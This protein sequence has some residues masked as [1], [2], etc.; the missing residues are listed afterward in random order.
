M[1]D[2]VEQLKSQASALSVAE[3]ADLAYFLLSSFEPE[4]EGAAQAWQEE[5][6]KRVVEIR[7]G[8]AVGRPVDEVLTELRERYSCLKEPTPSRVV[9]SP[10]TQLKEV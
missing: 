2:A 8:Q 3:K 5:I 4:E 10:A 1:T 7:S 6:A 9:G